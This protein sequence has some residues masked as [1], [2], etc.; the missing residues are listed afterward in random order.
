[1]NE[2]DVRM[3]QDI[4]FWWDENQ[5]HQMWNKLDDILMKIATDPE[6]ELMDQTTCMSIYNWHIQSYLDRT[7]PYEMPIYDEK[8]A[9][10][11]HMQTFDFAG[12]KADAVLS[13]LDEE[14]IIL[15]T[16][17]VLYNK[18]RSEQTEEMQQKL[19]KSMIGKFQFATI[20][21]GLKHAPQVFNTKL[22]ELGKQMVPDWVAPPE[23]I[24]DETGDKTG[25]GELGSGGEPDGGLHPIQVSQ[26][27]SWTTHSGGFFGQCSVR[28]G[29]WSVQP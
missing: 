11:R 4:R 15:S 13:H 28:A 14:P 21:Y 24:Q 19:Y 6:S 1:M 7:G 25:S 16:R 17:V 2:H 26:E 23:G 27:Q 12:Q 8:E 10:I 20:Q 22:E 3:H 29:E 18:D 9:Q 5:R